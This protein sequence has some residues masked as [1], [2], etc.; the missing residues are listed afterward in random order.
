MLKIIL[1]SSINPE[2]K[3]GYYN[4]VNDRVKF[5]KKEKGIKIWSYSI[6]KSTSLIRFSIKKNENHIFIEYPK[7][8]PSH[9]LFSFITLLFIRCIILF[10][11]VMLR[12]DMIHVH[13]GY[14]LAYAAVIIK[15][16]TKK[17][18]IIV[19]FHGSDVHTHPSRSKE[20]FVKTCNLCKRVDHVTAVSENLLLQLRNKFSVPE[21]KSS[22]T[23]NGVNLDETNCSISLRKGLTFSF[24]GNLNFT[25]G[26]DRIIPLYEA[27]SEIIEE[28]FTFYIG[29]DG[30]YYEEIKQYIIVNGISNIKLLG[31]MPRSDVK[32]IM[33]I[34]NCVFVL[35]RNEGL[36]IS[37]IEALAYS[38]LCI[39]PDIGGL[40]EVFRENPEL[41]I[42]EN[43]NPLDY[44]TKFIRCH[45]DKFKVN[46]T[47][48]FKN[49]SME[50]IIQK[51]IALYNEIMK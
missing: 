39:A 25:K 12:P 31:Y 6:Y 18:K 3:T 36:G 26:A 17:T 11:W 43:F 7:I 41:L 1:L 48:I 10:L 2:Q 14:P 40:S 15:R 4:A 19:T 29:G 24:F 42:K 13:W 37:A 45:K 16:L 49:F 33:G 27:L 8:F 44:A 22:I 35:S 51:E 47:Y 9:G 28:S 21:T 5:L 34:S 32:Q 23:Y 20:I 30:P 38:Q 50:N 46:R